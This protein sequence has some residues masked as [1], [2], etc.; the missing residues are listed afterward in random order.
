M[1]VS[2]ISN[3]LSTFSMTGAYAFLN[4]SIRKR[5]RRNK[6]WSVL[7][8]TVSVEKHN[9][10][11]LQPDSLFFAFGFV[12]INCLVTEHQ[13]YFSS[14]EQ[15]PAENRSSS[16]NTK[17]YSILAALITHLNSAAP[18]VNFIAAKAAIWN[19]HFISQS[20]P[21]HVMLLAI[22][23]LIKNKISKAFHKQVA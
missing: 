8:D 18:V 13:D 2:I 7:I 12:V 17:S 15:E 10:C 1:S 5:N 22:W 20:Q 21:I 11:R 3:M 19:V 16:K 6:L 14:F 4:F 9:K 23:C